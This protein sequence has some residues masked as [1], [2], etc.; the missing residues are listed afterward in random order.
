[1]RQTVLGVI[2]LTL[3][4]QF[5]IDLRM[6][7]GEKGGREGEFVAEFW[8]Q[9]HRSECMSTVFPSWTF[10]RKYVHITEVDF[11]CQKRGSGSVDLAK[12]G[13]MMSRFPYWSSVSET[14]LRRYFWKGLEL[15]EMYVS[16]LIGVKH[17]KKKLHLLK[18]ASRVP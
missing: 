9:K 6:T 3:P 13:E 7:H 4:G 18:Q 5:V 1:M 14:S 17:E 16:L 11:S 12:I 8:A 2:G 15:S 10:C